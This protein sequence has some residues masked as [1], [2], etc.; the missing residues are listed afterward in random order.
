[1]LLFHGRA[2]RVAETTARNLWISFIDIMSTQA[3]GIGGW[4]VG[5]VRLFE[6]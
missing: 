5:L 6:K 4:I 1:L 3:P 2:Q